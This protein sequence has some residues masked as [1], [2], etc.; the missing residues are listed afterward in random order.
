MLNAV[1]AKLTTDFGQR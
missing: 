1:D